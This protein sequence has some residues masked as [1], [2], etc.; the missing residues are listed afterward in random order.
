MRADADALRLSDDLDP[1]QQ[2]ARQCVR[3]RHA[4]ATLKYHFCEAHLCLHAPRRELVLGGRV[5][6]VV[7]VE[8]AGTQCSWAAAAVRRWSKSRS[9]PSGPIAIARHRYAL[10]FVWS[11]DL[12]SWP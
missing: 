8:S 9:C 12:S 1:L 7:V 3:V 10:A 11:A 5:A 2:K 4:A 6:L